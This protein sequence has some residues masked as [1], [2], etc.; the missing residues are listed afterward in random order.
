MPRRPSNGTITNRFGP[1]RNP[2]TGAAETHHGLD[3]GHD[4]GDVLIAPEDGILVAY[5]VVPGWEV[6]GRVAQILGATGTLH[7]LSHTDTLVT[8]RRV[9]DALTEG[10]PVALQGITGQTTGKHVHWET[11]VEGHRDDPE[12]WLA[13]HATTTSRTAPKEQPPMALRLIT[14]PFYRQAH[15]HVLTNG[16]DAFPID[17]AVA[18]GLRAG[19]VPV[20][21]YGE[22]DG[23]D[24]QQAEDAFNAEITLVHRFASNINTAAA[25]RMADVFGARLTAK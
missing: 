8:G 17:D 24:P 3:I 14:S 1:R 16:L 21:A 18:V 13:H 23:L 25:E 12:A 22:D 10:Q 15:Q 7:W 6:H 5:G 9:G 11:R 20:H 4:A 19:G 2:V